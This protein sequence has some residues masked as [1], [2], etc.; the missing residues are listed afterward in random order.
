[1]P[2][3]VAFQMHW[4]THTVLPMAVLTGED[5]RQLR[6]D[7]KRNIWIWEASNRSA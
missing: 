1:M 4:Q 7:R 6:R 3:C 2:G 5:C